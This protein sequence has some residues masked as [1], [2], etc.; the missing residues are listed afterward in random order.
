MR[1]RTFRRP[2]TTTRDGRARGRGGR[3]PGDESLTCPPLAAAHRCPA[4]RGAAPGR[5]AASSGRP[6]RTPPTGHRRRPRTRARCPSPLDT[7]TPSAPTDGD[8][9]TVSGTVTN[10]G[11]QTV[12]DAHVGLRVGSE[13]TTRSAIDNAARSSGDLQGAGGRRSAASTSRSSPSSRPASPSTSPSPCRSTSWTSAS[14]ASTSS[15]SP[16][17]GQT[18]AQPWD[19]VLGIQRTFLPWQPDEADTKTKTTVPVAADLHR[20]H[21]GGDGIQR[22]ADAGL[23]QRRPRQGDL[24]RAAVWTRWCRWARTST[25]PG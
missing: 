21:D 25:S 10:N 17:P 24:A 5:P 22:A 19:Q 8:T 18:A 23:P 9:L 3:L 2:L 14:T 6:P 7:L 4:R 1:G 20:P 13:L 16:S 15:A 12:T 11:K